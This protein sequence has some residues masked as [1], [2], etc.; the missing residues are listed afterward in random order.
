MLEGLH[1]FE[2]KNRDGW[3]SVVHKKLQRCPVPPS[4]SQSTR[5]H[6]TA[7]LCPFTC[8]RKQLQPWP[9]ANFSSLPSRHAMWCSGLRL[10]SKSRPSKPVGCSVVLGASAAHLCSSRA[11]SEIRSTEEPLSRPRRGSIVLWIML[12]AP[13]G[14]QA[15]QAVTREP[16]CEQQCSTPVD[17]LLLRAS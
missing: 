11:A 2:I 14:G 8:A 16:T 9:G 5:G 12:Q 6:P 17:S 13:F 4:G 15:S 3:N 7:P 1:S 10:A